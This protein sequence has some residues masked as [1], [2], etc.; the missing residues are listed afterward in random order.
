M[1][2]R[3]TYTLALIAVLALQYLSFGLHYLALG[4]GNIVVPIIIAAAMVGV[5]AM[6]F[7]ELRRA[8]A[9]ARIVAV[10]AVLFVALLCLG[11]AGDV[12]FR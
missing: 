2:A 3:T 5:S 1:R 11:V 8:S 4:A 6:V 10:L 12:A 9:V 7:M